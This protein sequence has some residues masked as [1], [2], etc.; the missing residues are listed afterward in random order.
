MRCK[1]CDY[2]LWNL[3]ARECPE[4]GTPFKPSDYEFTLNSVRFCCPH[5]GQDYYGTGEKGH[6][7][8]RQFACVSCGQYVDMDQ[9]VLLP[10]EGVQEEQTKVDEMPWLERSRRGFFAAWFTTIGRAMVAPHR[11]MDSI[12]DGAP[13]GYLFGGITTAIFY[14]AGISPIFIVILLAGAGGG[15]AT[16]IAAGMAGGFG[17]VLLAILVGAFVLLALW[18][19]SAHAILHITGGTAHPIRRTSQAI[20]YSAGANALAALPCI[21]LYFFWLW[22]IWWV[23]SATIMLARAQRVSGGRATAA[24][25][26]LPLLIVLGGGTL[27]GV[28]MFGAVRA[29]NTAIAAANSQG[30]YKT[31][32]ASAQSMV[33]ALKGFADTN[34]GAW[35]SDPMELEDSLLVSSEDFAP[36]TR[37]PSTTRAGFLPPGH[38]FV[39]RRMGDYV[40]TFYCIDPRTADPGLWLFVQCPEPGKVQFTGHN[41]YQVGLL[42]GTTAT[43]VAGEPFS[44]ALA[45]QNERR[46]AAGLPALVDPAK[47]T[48]E[49]PQTVPNP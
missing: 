33:Q 7:V 17:G 6:L 4:C 22:G 14:F 45:D 34:N 29:A 9:C 1:T 37:S 21:T 44:S 31:P 8:P 13:S 12:P 27:L 36:L 5:C 10:T 18:V 24:I 15:S 47:V 39:A 30:M 38:R 11:L 25:L 40:F 41:L 42:D 23:V 28:V 49:L 19:G 46:A 3:K 32:D 26:T 20:C 43:F 35:P 16:R 2:T 48:Q